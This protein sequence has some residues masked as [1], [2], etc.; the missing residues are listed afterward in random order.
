MEKHRALLKWTFVVAALFIAV[1]WLFDPFG[2]S[3]E[4]KLSEQTAAAVAS[5]AS[6]PDRQPI[7]ALARLRAFLAR[8]STDSSSSDELTPE[9]RDMLHELAAKQE[10]L[11]GSFESLQAR[12]EYSI[13]YVADE[14]AV[15][16]ALDPHTRAA[17]RRHRITV[18]QLARDL[19]R[20]E[21]KQP[22]RAQ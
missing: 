12:N 15:L 19:V 4:S 11:G 13:A 16:E 18:S 6:T 17:L 3:D 22:T 2:R 7:S 20:A 5:Q 8:G 9:T 21:A 10:R 1:S 14:R